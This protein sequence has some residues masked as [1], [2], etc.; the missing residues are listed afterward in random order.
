PR[1]SDLASQGIV[2]MAL[3]HRALDQ[4]AAALGSEE[5]QAASAN[6]RWLED[7]W[8]MAASDRPD[9]FAERGRRAGVLTDGEVFIALNRPLSEDAAP[10]L[11]GAVLT[12][13]LAP[14][15]VV[16]TTTRAAAEG[17]S[18]LDEVWRI[19]LFLVL[20]ALLAEL[21]LCSPEGSPPKGGTE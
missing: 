6:E 15:D 3:V 4:A 9:S 14:L 13:S 21:L 8:S 2:F 10:A 20:G 16:V 19:F 18:L 1:S 7:R 17:G 12:E 11:P 5:Q